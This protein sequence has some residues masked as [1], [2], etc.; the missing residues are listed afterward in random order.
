VILQYL[1]ASSAYRKVSNPEI[2]WESAES[3][4][5]LIAAL[6]DDVRVGNWIHAGA[7]S[8]NRP[9]PIPRPGTKPSVKQTVGRAVPIEEMDKLLGRT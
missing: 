2:I 8:S 9:K 6:I 7:K 4:P 1:P 3:L 5:M